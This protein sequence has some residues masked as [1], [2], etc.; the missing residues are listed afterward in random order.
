MKKQQLKLNQLKVASF[1]T[2]LNQGATRLGGNEKLNAF[3]V[4][5]LGNNVGAD[6]CQVDTH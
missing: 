4:L 2:L 5:T 3:M 1:V 6:F